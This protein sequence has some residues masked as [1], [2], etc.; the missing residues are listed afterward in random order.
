LLRRH[1][2]GYRRTEAESALSSLIQGYWIAFASSGD[3]N[4]ADNDRPGA[5]PV[6]RTRWERY[7]AANEAYVDLDDKPTM[8]RGLHEAECDFWDSIMS[9]LR[10]R[11]ADDDLTRGE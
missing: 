1:P 4:G 3:P 8:N 11:S 10:E 9:T 7:D 5:T 6:V 2:N